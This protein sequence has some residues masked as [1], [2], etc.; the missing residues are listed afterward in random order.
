VRSDHHVQVFHG[1]PVPGVR[2]LDPSLWGGACPQHFEGVFPPPGRHAWR[3]S[4]GASG[5]MH[6]KGTDGQGGHVREIEV[7]CSRGFRIHQSLR[8]GFEHGIIGDIA[9]VAA[10]QHRWERGSRSRQGPVP[11][12]DQTTEPKKRVKQAG[13][14]GLR[15]DRAGDLGVMCGREM[16][17]L[18]V[19]GWVSI[20]CCGGHRWRF[21]WGAVGS[22]AAH[23]WERERL[24][25][26]AAERSA[27]SGGRAA[28]QCR[29]GRRGVQ[30]CKGAKW[31]RAC[32]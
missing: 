6:I 17:G 9:K 1:V 30:G 10:Y 19:G 23:G 3:V 32:A 28:I 11:N 25:C 21:G 24:V 7:P 22:T 12:A 26:E 5:D 2:G 20:G 29:R 18:G 8:I 16:R 14:V 15:G 4:I 27:R 31:Q 13:W